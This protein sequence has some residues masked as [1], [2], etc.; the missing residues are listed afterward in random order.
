M[1]VRGRG[2]C[3]KSII[4]PQNFYLRSKRKLNTE[5]VKI[6][7]HCNS[8]FLLMAEAQMESDRCEI[9]EQGDDVAENS[10]N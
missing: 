5:P 10:H 4:P 7:K 8:K 6:I 2:L 9:E 3:R 1:D